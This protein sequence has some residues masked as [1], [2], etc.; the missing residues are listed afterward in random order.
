[1]SDPEAAAAAFAAQ[2]QQQQQ[3]AALQQQQLAA[4]Q[5]QELQRQ[6]LA[7]QLI[8]GVPGIQAPAGASLAVAAAAQPGGYTQEQITIDR[9]QREIYIGNLAVGITTKELLREFFDQVFAHLVPD[10]AAN[11]PVVNVNM[12]TGGR[13]AFVEFQNRDMATKALEMDKVVDLCGRVMNIGRPKGYVEPGPNEPQLGPFKETPQG[14]VSAAAGAAGNGAAGAAGAAAAPKEVTPGNTTVVLLSNI[15]PAGELRTE[16]DRRILQDEVYEEAAKYGSVSG[17]VVATPTPQVQDLM[18]GR[19]YIRYNTPEDA[20]KGQLAFHTRTLDDNVIKALFVPEE[21]FSRAQGGEWVFKHSGVA[22][23]PLPGLYGTNPLVSGITGLSALNPGLATL[24]ASNPGIAAMLATSINE[25][26]VP[27]EEGWVKLRGFTPTVTKQQIVE[28]LR[29]TAPELQEGDIQL[30]LSADGTPL[31]EAF[32]HLHGRRAKLR[33]ALALD[34]AIMPTAM[35]PV[36]VM[37]A[38]GEDAQRR[39]LSGCRL[40]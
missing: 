4:L 31:G 32:V 7:Q 27:F 22:G 6:L 16:A 24:V 20:A 2:M 35:C 15:L 39:I 14:V 10:P 26:E 34:R 28:F 19:C 21:E 12:D 38:V 37:T 36:E 1:M 13:F 23:I 18:P 17:V 9:K 33:L 5:Q 3:L 30:V 8:M 11:P 40:V 29:P 25:D